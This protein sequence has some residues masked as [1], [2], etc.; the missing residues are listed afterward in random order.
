MRNL[1]TRVKRLEEDGIE[2]TS[3]IVPVYPGQSK[4][5]AKEHYFREHPAMRGYVGASPFL[6]V[7]MFRD[8]AHA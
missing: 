3:M 4:D 7:T 5:E 6:F 8:E 1:E 2:E